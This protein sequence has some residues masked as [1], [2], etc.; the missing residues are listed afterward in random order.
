[1]L[2]LTISSL[3]F[4]ALPDI[5]LSPIKWFLIK[6]VFLV[7][8]P[9]LIL[10]ELIKYKI[11]KIALAKRK[12]RKAEEKA[13]RVKLAKPTT[14]KTPRPRRQTTT[15]KKLPKNSKDDFVI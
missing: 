2:I 11:N 8:V 14:T 3:A 4:A 10:V 15:R 7:A 13:K 5:D 9:I 6:W 12:A 1:M